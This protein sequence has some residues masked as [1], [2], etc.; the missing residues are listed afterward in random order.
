MRSAVAEVTQRIAEREALVPAAEWR[1]RECA[2]LDSAHADVN[3]LGR[4]LF[5]GMRRNVKSAEEGAITW[6]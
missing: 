5:A 1:R 3:G 6:M 2:T 4:E